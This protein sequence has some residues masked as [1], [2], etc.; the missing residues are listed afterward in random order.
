MIERQKTY[1]ATGGNNFRWIIQ[2]FANFLHHPIVRFIANISCRTCFIIHFKFVF[3]FLKNFL[4]I[5]P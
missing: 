1:I 5:I 4:L 2:K 3:E